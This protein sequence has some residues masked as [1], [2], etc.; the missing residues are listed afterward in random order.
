[1]DQNII[2]E[3]LNRI[4][5]LEAENIRIKEEIRDKKLEN[6]KKLEILKLTDNPEIFKEGTSLIIF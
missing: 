5:S 6:S 3:M 4:N 2:D 1:M